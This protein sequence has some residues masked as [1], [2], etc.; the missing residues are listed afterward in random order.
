LPGEK[1][2]R[3]VHGEADSLPG[4]VVDR[5][6][7]CLVIQCFAAGIETR[8]EAIADALSELLPVDGIW[9]KNDFAARDS[10]GLPRY[11]RLLTGRMPEQVAIHEDGAVFNVD[12]ESGQKS[13]YYFDQR[14]ARRRTK[15]WARD[16]RV[17]DLF[18]YTGSFTVNAALGG[19]A[20]VL[21]IESSLPALEVARKNV[22]LNHTAASTELRAEDVFAALRVLNQSREKFDIIIVD[23]PA[24]CKRPRDR[25]RALAAYRDLAYQSSRLL[26]NSG[27]LLISSCSHHFGWQELRCAVFQAAH[28]VGRD[29][30]LIEQLIAGPDHPVLLSVPETEYLRTLILELA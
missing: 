5:Y 20:R 29:L 10:E 24:L 18:C 11:S 16:K 12:I 13:G 4:L 28:G 23:P 14:L 26:A 6:D 8:L 19:A 7:R 17:L 22:E 21:G 15:E 27:R 30:R 25:Q 1:D 3:L 9:L 2:Y